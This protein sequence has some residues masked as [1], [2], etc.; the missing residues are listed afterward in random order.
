MVYIRFLLDLPVP[1][2]DQHCLQVI[3][4]RVLLRRV[5]SGGIVTRRKCGNGFLHGSYHFL[6]MPF[7]LGCQ[8]G[9][10]LR[11]LLGGFLFFSFSAT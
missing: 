9:F 10:F 7:G 4:Q 1:R 3:G 11:L 5:G 2:L 8:F 6:L